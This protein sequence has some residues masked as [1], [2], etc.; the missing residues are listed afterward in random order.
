MGTVALLAMGTNGRQRGTRA[1]GVARGRAAAGRPA[2]GASRRVR[3]VGAGHRRHPAARA[4]LARR[5]GAVAAA[6]AGRGDRGAGAPPSSPAR[7]WSRRSRARSAWSRSSPTWW[8]RRRSGRPP[9]SGWRAAWLGLVWPAAGPARRH[10]R[11]LVRGLDRRWSPAR[12]AALPAA[13]VDW[14]TGVL[15]LALLTALTVRLALARRR[16]CCAGAVTGLGLL[17][18]ARRR[19]PGPPAHAG[20]AA[21]RL[22][23]GRVRRRPGRRAGPPRRPGAGVVVDAGPD[24]APVDAACA[25]STSTTCRCWC[26]PTSTPTTSTG[27]PACST[28]AGS[29]RSRPPA[30]LDPPAG[31]EEVD[32]AAAGAR[33]DAGR[34][35][36]TAPPAA[37]AQVTLQV[38][39]PPA[40]SPTVGPG[41]GSTANDA[42]VVLLA[43]GPRACACC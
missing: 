3:A 24:P 19:R 14:G 4:R 29:A 31:V 12:G 41:D 22:G 34:R 10:A 17:R 15:P 23:A 35:R 20:L 36:R 25:G 9:C 7:R 37:S 32:A 30:S 27:S 43:R 42:S 18:A 28:G 5:A 38:L 33:L 13:A 21:R 8:S 11:G 40:D 1:L 16:G 39:W 2:A 26:S 6:L